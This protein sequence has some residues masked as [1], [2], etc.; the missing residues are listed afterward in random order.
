M[1]S[2]YRQFY[3]MEIDFK[4]Y[5]DILEIPKHASQSEIKTAYYKLSKTYHPD[6][7]HGCATSTQKFK[8]ITEAYEVLTNENMRKLYNKN[9]SSQNK[10]QISKYTHFRNI[11]CPV[12]FSQLIY[13]RKSTYNFDMWLYNHYGQSMEMRNTAKLRYERKIWGKK[14]AQNQTEKELVVFCFLLLSFCF[15]VYDSQFTLD[16]HSKKNTEQLP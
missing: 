2:Q 12:T 11:N 16:Q 8:Y 14:E 15:F 13:Q 6:K 7:N 10:T 9:F 1:S 3:T 5:Y 4:N